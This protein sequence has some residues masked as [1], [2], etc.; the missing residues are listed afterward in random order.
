[1]TDK[2]SFDVTER[3]GAFWVDLLDDGEPLG[4]YP[5]KDAAIQAIVTRLVDAKIAGL[6]KSANL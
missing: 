1:M 4:P 2:L 3:D 5:T 6:R